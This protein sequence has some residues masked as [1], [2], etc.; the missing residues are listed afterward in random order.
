MRV[1][2]SALIAASVLSAQ[3]ML[4]GC[5]PVQSAA[6][7]RS[8][9]LL[10]VVLR[11]AAEN[12]TQPT[13]LV[14]GIDEQPGSA[15]RLFAFTVSTQIPGEYAAFLLRIDLPAGS[16]RL[17]HVS[18]VSGN[19]EVTRP[20][21]V[22]T[23]MPLDLKPGTQY[24]GCIELDIASG[25][26]LMVLADAYENDLPKLVRTWPALRGQTVAHRAAPGIVPIPARIRLANPRSGGE[27]GFGA[28][29]RLDS[30][31]ASA[32]PVKA[33]AAFQLFLQSGHP[34]AFAVAESGH[35]GTAAG[36]TDVIRRAMQSCRRVQPGPRKSV[37]K[38]FALDDTLISSM[39]AA[40]PLVADKRER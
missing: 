32:L 12:E 22:M 25:S 19:G 35:A 27:K 29:A 13:G 15:G 6:H 7:A 40:A 33:R 30:S 9:V 34:R 31:V 4:S 17:T 21:D 8:T 36:G 3:A 2:R 10:S 16:H 23:D 38:L 26:P 1:L 24:A 18:G 20:F 28:A 11:G 5:L 39:Q 37:C 14:V